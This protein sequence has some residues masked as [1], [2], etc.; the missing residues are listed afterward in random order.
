M[1][2]V[3]IVKGVMRMDSESFM[4]HRVEGY[5]GQGESEKRKWENLVADIV[6]QLTYVM[7]MV[8]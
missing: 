3:G 2:K 5:Y 7:Y 6:E 4:L 1:G 8:S